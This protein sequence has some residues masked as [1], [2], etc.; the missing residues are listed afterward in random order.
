MTDDQTGM[1]E[2]GE[3]R[4]ELDSLSAMVGELPDSAQKAELSLSISRLTRILATRVRLDARRTELLAE[5]EL[6]LD[7]MRIE[8][9]QARA[10]RDEA[11]A[12]LAGK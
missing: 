2:T 7:R 8:M 9:L 1:Q 4:A 5:A 11:L 6:A 10:E 3:Y 12:R